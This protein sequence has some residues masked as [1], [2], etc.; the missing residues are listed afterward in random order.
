[1]QN[2]QVHALTNMAG[3]RIVCPIYTNNLVGAQSDL[4]AKWLARQ[5]LEHADQGRSLCGHLLYIIF[6]SSL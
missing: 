3:S 6:S 1:M 2:F 4:V 5:T